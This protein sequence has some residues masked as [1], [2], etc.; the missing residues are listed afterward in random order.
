[1]R[2][3]PPRHRFIPDTAPRYFGETYS[4]PMV[5]ID[6]TR[7]SDKSEVVLDAALGFHRA[8]IALAAFQPS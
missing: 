3:V 1:M 5:C 7:A 2:R 8:S 6:A 4:V